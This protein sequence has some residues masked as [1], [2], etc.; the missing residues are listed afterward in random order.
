MTKV[1]LTAKQ[2]ELLSKLVC[3]GHLDT[4]MKAYDWLRTWNALWGYLYNGWLDEYP[5][6]KQAARDL[7]HNMAQARAEDVARECGLEVGE[8][9]ALAPL[10]V[11]LL[12]SL[13]LPTTIYTGLP[14]AEWDYIY[15]S[16]M[17]AQRSV[18][19]SEQFMGEYTSTTSIS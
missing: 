3:P 15:D 17:E 1:N 8:V 13:N 2:S 18:G 4:D 6:L 9:V 7:I 14:A 5:D 19:I 11:E 12:L 16:L 10:Q